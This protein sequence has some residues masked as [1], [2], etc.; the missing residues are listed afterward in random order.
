ML[1]GYLYRTL[2][3]KLKWLSDAHP[4]GKNNKKIIILIITKQE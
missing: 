1:M 2:S 4:F 3:Q